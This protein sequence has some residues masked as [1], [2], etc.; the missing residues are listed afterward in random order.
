MRVGAVDV[1]VEFALAQDDEFLLRVRMRR[2]RGEVRVQRADVRLEFAQRDRG[3][4]GD[5]TPLANTG[6]FGGEAFPSENGGA[7]LRGF[8]GGKHGGQ[9]KGWQQPAETGGHGEGYGG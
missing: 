7:K 2:M 8:G 1:H 9:G 4:A 6:G 3:V 5:F